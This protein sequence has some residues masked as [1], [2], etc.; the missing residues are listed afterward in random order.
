[1]HPVQIRLSRTALVVID[2]WPQTFCS[3]ATKWADELANKIGVFMKLAR[4]SG[5]RIIHAPSTGA[6]NIPIYARGNALAK[7]ASHR[8][9]VLGRLNITPQSIDPLADTGPDV[10]AIQVVTNTSTNHRHRSV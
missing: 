2:M 4:S 10:V 5:I 7:Y 1:L 3:G 8:E 6:G 9:M